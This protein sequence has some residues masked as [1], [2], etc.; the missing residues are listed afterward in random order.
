MAREILKQSYNTYS[1]IST[2]LYKTDYNWG[3]LST[4]DQFAFCKYP[5]D[6]YYINPISSEIDTFLG[7]YDVFDL[8]GNVLLSNKVNAT[9][10]ATNELFISPSFIAYLKNSTT[11]CMLFISNN[12]VTTP[13]IE[14]QIIVSTPQ[15]SSV[16][17]NNTTQESIYYSYT[18]EAIE[19]PTLKEIKPGIIEIFQPTTIEYL[20][21]RTASGPLLFTTTN[22][23]SKVVNNNFLLICTSNYSKAQAAKFTGNPIS[24]ITDSLDIYITV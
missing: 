14:P 7:P 15:R 19:P 5:G 1:D 6:T 11:T 3:L 12:A 16:S 17:I 4:N 8:H 18:S 13:Y 2:I 9:F 24:T 22:T 21:I 23:R 20:F 10:K